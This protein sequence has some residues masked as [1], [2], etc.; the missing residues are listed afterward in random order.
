MRLRPI[1]IANTLRFHVQYDIAAVFVL[2]EGR[3]QRSVPHFGTKPL[4]RNKGRNFFC[5]VDSTLF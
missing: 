5:P 1:N 4:V 3:K 2:L